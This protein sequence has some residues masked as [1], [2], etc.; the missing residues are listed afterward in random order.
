VVQDC[1][2]ILCG[3]RPQLMVNHQLSYLLFVM[4]GDCGLS[5]CDEGVCRC[6]YPL[7]SLQFI[8]QPPLD[9]DQARKED[10][11]YDVLCNFIF[12][13]SFCFLLS[14]SC[15]VFYFL[16]EYHIHEIPF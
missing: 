3:V 13:W 15:I 1:K 4:S 10:S 14:I 16:N 11:E 7:M 9:D 12:Y 2:L 5:L 6:F 8:F